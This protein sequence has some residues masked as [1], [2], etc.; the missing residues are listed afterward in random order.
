MHTFVNTYM[1]TFVNTYMHTFVNTYMLMCIHTCS[2]AYKHM[3]MYV[4]TKGNSSGLTSKVHPDMRD[5]IIVEYQV[6][7]HTLVDND[8]SHLIYIQ[9]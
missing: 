5:I 3:Y 9:I 1:H 8:G 6:C 2:C 7:L 4:C